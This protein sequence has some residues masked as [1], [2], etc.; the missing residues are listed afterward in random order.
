MMPWN[1]W[2]YLFQKRAAVLKSA[3][4]SFREHD[5]EEA[6]TAYRASLGNGSTELRPNVR[7]RIVACLDNLG[8]RMEADREAAKLAGMLQAVPFTAEIAL[9]LGRLENRRDRAS[10]YAIFERGLSAPGMSTNL[11]S[12][13]KCELSH[14]GPFVGR[15]DLTF[16]WATNGLADNPPEPYLSSH[17][18][19]AGMS[20]I[21]LADIDGA[22]RYYARGMEQAQASNDPIRIAR[23]T[24]H[25]AR[26]HIVRGDYT[27]GIEMSRRALEMAPNDEHASI[28]LYLA[29]ALWRVDKHE[30]AIRL[31]TD[32]LTKIRS[33]YVR[34]NNV[35]LNA[36]E[37]T[38]AGLALTAGEFDRAQR[39]YDRVA[40]PLDETSK[41]LFQVKGVCLRAMRNRSASSGLSTMYDIL[42]SSMHERT[43]SESMTWIA[44]AAVHVG[45]PDLTRKC[46]DRMRNQRQLPIE[47]AETLY[48][49]GEAKRLQ[50]DL[51]GA[52]QSFEQA[53][54]S[55]IK[56]IYTERAAKRLNEMKL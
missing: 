7:R 9:A 33:S 29:S 22:D 1:D 34:Y 6:L 21:S 50:G 48:L 13:L 25:L 12:R 23:A 56:D 31:L 4:H 42:P 53:V 8:R 55:G 10:A 40:V 36:V 24:V 26:L 11:R 17:L 16:Y 28:E 41:L 14:V 38:L 37:L 51:D 45:L 19:M 18:T 3:D 2:K 43:L 47:I 52:R 54:A 46:V 39:Y 20:S 27:T 44:R 15:P 30:E 5:F 35:T 32:K 49:E